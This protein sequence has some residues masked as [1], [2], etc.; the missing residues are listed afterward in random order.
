MYSQH[1][2]NCDL[3]QHSKIIWKT[4]KSMLQQYRVLKC[5]SIGL[6][7]ADNLTVNSYSFMQYTSTVYN[8]K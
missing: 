7:V 1:V 2:V 6:T 5:D 8:T 4:I 3:S